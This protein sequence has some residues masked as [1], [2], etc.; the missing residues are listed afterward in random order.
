MP[1]AG[2]HGELAS[3][4]M[5]K[6]Y[7]E[8]RGNHGKKVVLTPDTA[9]GTNPASATMAGF[10]CREVPSGPDGYTCATKTSSPT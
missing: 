5:I 9:H 10:R 2:A 1:A 6:A 8:D 3:V 4:F 7:H